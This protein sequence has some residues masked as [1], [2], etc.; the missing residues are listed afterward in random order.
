MDIRLIDLKKNSEER[1]RAHDFSLFWITIYSWKESWKILL[2]LDPYEV[3]D[4]QLHGDEFKLDM[5]Y[6]KMKTSQKI[7]ES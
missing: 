4:L 7:D 6:E 3:K 2:T 1:R 5:A